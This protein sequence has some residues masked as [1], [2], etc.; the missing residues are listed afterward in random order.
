LKELTTN[1]ERALREEVTKL[2]TRDQELT[3]MFSELKT[4]TD[5]TLG[6]LDNRVTNVETQMSTVRGDV[7]SSFAVFKEEIGM[8]EEEL[9][10]QVGAR[11]KESQAWTT[12]LIDDFTR[13]VGRQIQTLEETIGIL[14][15]D[16]TMDMPKLMA[17]LRTA[18]ATFNSE[19]TK[20]D[21]RIKR[22]EAR[23][24][25]RITDSSQK[26]DSDIT[27]LHSELDVVRKKFTESVTAK[28]AEER[29]LSSEQ[30]AQ[31]EAEVASLTERLSEGQHE[32]QT[33]NAQINQTVIEL[34]QEMRLFTKQTKTAT[35]ELRT[36]FDTLS[37]ESQQ[38]RDSFAEVIESNKQSIRQ[39]DRKVLAATQSLETGLAAAKGE[40]DESLKD[41]RG[42]IRVQRE[43]LTALAEQVRVGRVDW[44][45]QTTGLTQR[46]DELGNHLTELR[47]E[48]I[49]ETTKVTNEINEE[50]VR[51][52][53]II[54]SLTGESGLDFP[55]LIE[56]LKKLK[57][58]VTE[59]LNRGDERF[60]R[61]RGKIEQSRADLRTAQEAQ[62]VDLHAEIARACSAVE[63]TSQHSFDEVSSRLDHDSR[64]LANRVG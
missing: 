40:F 33:Q 14:R 37:T 55:T 19:L 21:E 59:N 47:T 42:Q 62:S 50:V 51:L 53:R 26:A 12:A 3:V 58:Q 8:S 13:K 10:A 4:Q 60:K 2:M 1:Q 22:V 27:A 56:N 20:T 54:E 49:Q 6:A 63:L 15:T 41:L 30:S 28:L 39:F 9:K 25:Q 57:E 32:F 61:H 18:H 35:H 29:K 45:T 48:L 7:K 34:H 24:Q 52:R 31:L 64:L 36:S 16:G 38:I 17:D 5:G 46:D 43:N 23:L 11:I 44:E